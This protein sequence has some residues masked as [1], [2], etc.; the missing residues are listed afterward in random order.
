MPLL[1]HVTDLHLYADVRRTLKG[2]NTLASFKAILKLADRRHGSAELMILGGDL[3]Q[4]EAKSTYKRLVDEMGDSRPFCYVPGNHD[5]IENM[6]ACL[7][8][9]PETR[10][11]ADWQ[12]IFL[13][14]K[15]E[16]EIGGILS[17]E[18]LGSLEQQ[19]V[20]GR[21]K[22]QL[23]VMHHHPIPVG[24]GWLDKIALK[25]SDA[26]WQIVDRHEGVRGVLFG[27][28]HQ[29]FEQMRGEIKVMGS[30]STCIQFKPNE[31][32]FWLDE[33]HPGYRWLQL[34]ANGSIETGVERAVGFMPVDLTDTIGY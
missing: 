12:I 28:V 15:D 5:D 3:A 16:G 31:E 10:D 22:Y 9:L 13:N 34:N 17:E 21:G 4:D 7:G 14:T 8:P 23:I 27:H 30:P 24:S 2:V 11:L 25:N 32:A 19:L 20:K 26:F 29:Q 6:Q 33:A 1:I 18:E